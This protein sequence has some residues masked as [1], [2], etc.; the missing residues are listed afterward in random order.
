MGESES[1][2]KEVWAWAGGVS[3]IVSIAGESANLAYHN[4]FGRSFLEIAD[5][6]ESQL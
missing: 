6:I 4:D 1:L 3:E 5:A 2:P